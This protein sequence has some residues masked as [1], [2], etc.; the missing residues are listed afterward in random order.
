MCH[1]KLIVASVGILLIATVTGIGVAARSQVQTPETQ[2]IRTI[3]FQA[4]VP[5]AGRLLPEDKIV[6]VKRREI[7]DRVE[8]VTS[9]TAAERADYLLSRA[10]AAVVLTVSDISGEFTEGESWI[11]TEIRAIPTEVL[12]ARASGIAVR[13]PI[14][15]TWDDGGERVVDLRQVRAG[16]PLNLRKGDS[17]LMFLVSDGAGLWRPSSL[18]LAIERGRLVDTTQASKAPGETEP[19]EGLKIESVVKEI[20]RAAARMKKTQ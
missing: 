12:F 9:P 3:V 16:T 17:C 4:G 11:R 8:W 7:I 13:R 2:R 10:Q 20:R 1:E 19:L 18:P 5:I 6:V 14:R 15:I